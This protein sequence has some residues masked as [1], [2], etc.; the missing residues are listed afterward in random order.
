MSYTTQEL[1]NYHGVS[2]N[3]MYKYI[4]E[5]KINNEFEKR[6]PGRFYSDREAYQIADAIGFEIPSNHPTFP[7]IPHTG[8]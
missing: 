6:S 8:T 2:L 5:L 1:A 4:K 3:T 7:K